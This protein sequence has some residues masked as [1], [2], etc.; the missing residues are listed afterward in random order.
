MPI[1]PEFLERGSALQSPLFARALDR[2]GASVREL[3]VGARIGPYRVVRELGRG[4]MAV[5]YL[6][7][8]ADGEFEQTVALKLTRPEDDSSLGQ[9][10]LRHERQLL[11]GL[12]HPHI[13]RL[14]DGGRN[15]DGSLWFALEFVD[16]ARIDRYCAERELSAPARL[17]LFMQ[18][19]DAVQFAHAH[20]L[21]HRDLKPSNILVGEGGVQL[22]DFGIAQLLAPGAAETA[23]AQR[24]LTPAWASPEQQRGDQATTASDI[25]QLGRLL[26][27]ILTPS[28]AAGITAGTVTAPPAAPAASTPPIAADLAAIIGK[29]TR[30]T[31]AERYATVTELRADVDNFLAHRPVLARRGGRGYRA[32][33]FVRRHRAGVAACAGAS[34]LLLASLVAV[35]WQAQIA[36]RAA[37]HAERS[38]VFLI[39]L[40][41]DAN[42]FSSSHRGPADLVAVLD[43]AEKR[44]DRDF[45][46]APQT[47][48][49]LHNTLAAA[50]MQ[51]NQ[52]ARARDIMR[53]S[54]AAMRSR[55]EATTPE[56]GDALVVLAQAESNL[57]DG[58]A[59]RAAFA[60]AEPLLAHAGSSYRRKYISLL[61]GLAKLDNQE[62]D[63]AAARRRHETILRERLALEGPQSPDIAMDLM[64]RAADEFD[65]E[66][67]A[68]A[69][70]LAQQ[71]HAMLLALLGP[72]HARRIY[73]DDM[74][75]AAQ[76][77]AGHYRESLATIA[78]IVPMARATLAPGATMLSTVLNVYASALRETGDLA[79][80]LSALREANAIGA[81]AQEPGRGVTEFRLG[82]VEAALHLPT[83]LG[84]LRDS[85]DALAAT[86]GG[87][88][89]FAELAR[90]SYGAALARSGEVESGEAEATAARTA[91][92]AGKFSASVKLGDI[93]L[94]LAEVETLRGNRAAAQTLR[95]EALTVFR[96]VYGVDHPKTRKL[97]AQTS[98]P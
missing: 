64:N 11:A 46:D 14:L 50:L 9:A 93:D 91:L 56:F 57:G 85:R 90:A 2:L 26:Q 52:Y 96:R 8:R 51:M 62:G 74:L 89:G 98:T 53:A 33:C 49:E 61:T 24:A 80:A 95:N 31:P 1:D 42:P 65:Q 5:V 12:N 17:E 55:R 81:A 7:E 86:P 54:T 6:A 97:Q 10:L 76:R 79:G 68:E 67:Y 70:T 60:E 88:D 18:A 25:Y 27:S 94:A 71:S 35:V 47:Q 87:N 92:L 32:A 23:P 21:I 29:A 4:G 78:P 45:A 22:L 39:D 15:D 3:P 16:G 28:A 34:A 36:H 48:A 41:R 20:L 44:V 84:T 30:A 38:K 72:D 82:E 37:D 59:A 69:E 66:H 63:H 73:V 58:K 40:L 43:G 19:C 83:A 77:E 75:A 13:A